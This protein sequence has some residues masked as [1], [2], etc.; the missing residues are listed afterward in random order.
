MA[1][2]ASPAVNPASLSKSASNVLKKK[3]P[4]QIQVLFDGN[5]LIELSS[6]LSLAD[7]KSKSS[8]YNQTISQSSKKFECSDIC[9]DCTEFVNRLN[10]PSAELFK[11]C[12]SFKISQ[13]NFN[14]ECTEE[15]IEAENDCEIDETDCQETPQASREPQTNKR[16]SY[17][18]P[19]RP[20]T[21]I[22]SSISEVSEQ[23]KN[24]EKPEVPEVQKPTVEKETNQQPARP[25]SPDPC[26]EIIKKLPRKSCEVTNPCPQTK[27][28]PRGSTAPFKS[29]YRRPCKHDF[30][31]D[32]ECSLEPCAAL[33]ALKAETEMKRKCREKKKLETVKKLE[34]EKKKMLP[35]K[36]VQNENK[37]NEEHKDKKEEMAQKKGMLDM[38][39]EKKN[40]KG[41]KEGKQE[42][43]SDSRSED[44]AG[45]KNCDKIKGDD[46]SH[47]K[48]SKKY[49]KMKYEIELQNYWIDKMNRDLKSKILKCRPEHEICRMKDKIKE[50]IRKVEEMVR[51]ASCLQRSDP[52]EK[53]GPIPVSTIN[54]ETVGKKEQCPTEKSLK[55]PMTPSDISK[56][57]GFSELDEIKMDNDEDACLMQMEIDCKEEQIKGL[58]T[59]LVDTKHDLQKLVNERNLLN[60]QNYEPNPCEP[61]CKTC[62]NEIKCE[63]IFK[64][65][66]KDDWCKN[67][68][69]IK[70][71]D[72]M[73]KK[74]IGSIQNIKCNAKKLHQE[75]DCMKQIKT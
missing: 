4:G 24:N 64:P 37:E 44:S 54:E 21:N 33:D 66:K 39:K 57:S 14:S 42:K 15:D 63:E 38:K 22:K 10:S 12:I 3:K 30:P 26:A 28:P 71:V 36:K 5:D 6:I 56:L 8:L 27:Q 18:E 43:S 25:I 49:L 65:K 40:H 29:L 2:P 17:S 67:I 73:V 75:I 7:C 13:E 35:K 55:P 51:F 9:S 72:S 32:L 61:S 60:T 47:Q 16:P 41:K 50:E 53:W 62:N 46:D 74:M 69:T 31:V 52:T 34:T 11:K 48:F 58:C 23:Q 1:H 20:S 59:K 70:K 68:E 45:L 19:I